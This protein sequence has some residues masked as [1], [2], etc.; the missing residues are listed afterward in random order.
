MLFT[1]LTN[2]S[3]KKESNPS[4]CSS[5]VQSIVHSP[6]TPVAPTSLIQCSRVLGPLPLRRLLSIAPPIMDQQN[7]AVVRKEWG[8]SDFS[9]AAT[10]IN[11]LALIMCMIVIGVNVPMILIWLYNSLTRYVVFY[12]PPNNFQSWTFWENNHKGL[13]CC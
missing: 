2:R 12:V 4:T 13:V 7:H 6:C 3:I 1:P 10:V 5:T 8:L 9:T 11:L